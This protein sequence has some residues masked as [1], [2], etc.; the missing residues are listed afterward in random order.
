MSNPE[1]DDLIVQL[2][3]ETDAK[4]RREGYK[5]LADARDP[6]TIPALRDAYINDDDEKVKAIAHDALA[7]FKAIKEGKAGGGSQVLSL[8]LGLL[9]LSFIGSLVLNG[10]ALLAGEDDDETE[11]PPPFVAL[12][13]TDRSVLMQEMSDKLREH[14]TLVFNLR[15]EVTTYNDTGQVDCTSVDAYTLPEPYVLS[16]DDRSVY[17]DL[18]IL[19][20]ELNT[21]LP[22]FAATLNLLSMACRNPELQTKNVIGASTK[23]G[24]IDLQL[25]DIRQTLQQAIDHPAPTIF[26]TATL[27]P[28][29]DVPP[30]ATPTP[31]PPTAVG[32]IPEATEEVAV[33][34]TTAPTAV[35]VQDTP[36]P[37]LTPLPTATFTP[38]PT[39]TLPLPEL[40]YPVLLA[41]LSSLFPED[42]LLDLQ[43]PYGTGMLD[44][45]QQADSPRGQTTTNYCTLAPSWPAAFALTPEQ[46]ALL[47]DPA[48]NDTLLSEAIALQQ[49]GFG[50]ALQARGLYERDCADS[51]LKNSAPRGIELLEQALEDFDNAQARLD[52]IAAR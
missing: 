22:N 33:A 42:F 38:E 6:A 23:L 13:V 18:P 20:A 7:R 49:N 1:W 21:P 26:P 8:L 24:E 30:T 16:N 32:A 40:D 9:V 34:P 2:K 4:T 3:N 31:P 47:D 37:T 52:E 41:S 15:G 19:E 5:L 10:M 27:L 48:T 12:V 50:L 46:Q 43:N 39:A 14:D 51:Q 45:W 29:T 28:P 11:E 25:F 36:T 44:Q 35:V 17:P